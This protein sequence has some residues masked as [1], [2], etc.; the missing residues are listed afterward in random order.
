MA[1]GSASVPIGGKLLNT[2]LELAPGWMAYGL[3]T[4]TQARF[5][6]HH[7]NPIFVIEDEASGVPQIIDEATRS[8]ITSEGCK[9][10]KIGNPIDP[11]GHFYDSFNS[12]TVYQV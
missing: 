7:S 12:P 6:G 5:L 4:N 1:Y 3:S 2:S 10:I 11:A 8:L 9:L